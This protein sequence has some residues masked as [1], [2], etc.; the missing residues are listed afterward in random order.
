MN[1]QPAGVMEHWE[2]AGDSGPYQGYSDS[3]GI[4]SLANSRYMQ[5]DA[6]ISDASFIRLKNISLSYR[7]PQQWTKNLSCTLSIQ[8]QNVL[9]I[10]KYKGI[11]PEFK[12]TG[13]LPPLRVFTTT[14]QI[15]F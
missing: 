5:S 4:R 9:T 15:T 12:S 7:L 2:N 13:Y 10:T 14:I 11:D 3:N 6:S 1:N 8:G